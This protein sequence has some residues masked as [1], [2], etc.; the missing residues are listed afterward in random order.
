MHSSPDAVNANV[1][2]RAD[3]CGELDVLSE[4]ASESVPSNC[5][6]QRICNS[7]GKVEEGRSDVKNLVRLSNWGNMRGRI[8]RRV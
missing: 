5:F 4:R 7:G 6:D 3:V 2:G 1:L 8:V